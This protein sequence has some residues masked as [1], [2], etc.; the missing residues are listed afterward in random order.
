MMNEKKILDKL[1]KTISQDPKN[2]DEILKLSHNLAS[3]DKDNVRFSVDSS[4]IDRLGRELVARHETAVSELI[5]NAYDAD[6]SFAYLTF[7]N[8]DNT[9]GTLTIDDDGSGDCM[10]KSKRKDIHAAKLKWINLWLFY[11]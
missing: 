5:K 9:G 7:S 3:L 1:T 8:V 6:A 10:F 2:I 11:R 4:V